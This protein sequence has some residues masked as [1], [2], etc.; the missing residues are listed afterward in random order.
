MSMNEFTNFVSSVW[1]QT[2]FGAELGVWLSAFLLLVLG[3]VLRGWISRL[4]IKRLTRLAARSKNTFDDEIIVALDYPIRL[5]VLVAAVYFSMSLIPFSPEGQIIVNKL[6]NS[7]FLYAAFR[8]FLVMV[9]P[10]LNMTQALSDRLNRAL[11][12]WLK[13][14]VRIVVVIFGVAAICEVWGIPVASIIAGLG[15]VGAAIALGAQELFKN[16][17]SGI[18]IIA[19]KRFEVGDWI[20]V[21]GVVEGT[22]EWI[23]FRSSRVKRFDM[24]P[25]YVPN[26]YLADNPM[27]NFSKRDHRRI[28]MVVG[29][30]YATS[31]VALEK[32]RDNTLAWV[33]THP[34]IETPDQISTFVNIDCLQ[35]SSIGLMIYCFT[36]TTDWGEWL[37]VKEEMI[38][39]LKG[40]VSDAGSDFAFPSHNVYLK[41]TPTQ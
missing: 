40:I 4:I 20:K 26:H 3:I 31:Q 15:I 27:T 34:K 19:E 10:L 16:L 17:I 2:V 33:S 18:M 21:E 7:V 32:I 9:D 11:T 5:L 37:N 25:V 38:L 12:D 39:A 23:G 28:Y 6:I 29:L 41:E 14:I 35:D 30:E 1:T 8:A 22:I 24:G 13:R 36:N